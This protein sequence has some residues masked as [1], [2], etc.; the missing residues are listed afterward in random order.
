MVLERLRFH[1]NAPIA[2]LELPGDYLKEGLSDIRV[3]I[4]ELI[5]LSQER[6]DLTIG[7]N[8]DPLKGSPYMRPWPTIHD[9]FK[10]IGWS[11]DNEGKSLTF[12]DE[13]DWLS[14]TVTHGVEQ[15]K[16]QLTV[17]VNKNSSL[18]ELQFK[19][20]PTDGEEL[21]SPDK[22]LERSKQ[23]NLSESLERSCDFSSG[24]AVFVHSL[25]AVIQDSRQLAFE[26]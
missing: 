16:E 7:I 8:T 14:F 13:Q 20:K 1:R 2:Q 23:K 24:Q 6:P 19:I 11:Y 3:G 22:K 12:S 25:K 9:F 26:S 10:D 17:L 21:S 15:R 5:R 4:L 18:I